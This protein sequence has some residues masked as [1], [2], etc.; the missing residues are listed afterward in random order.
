MGPDE[1]CMVVGKDLKK[2][3]E[4]SSSFNS[5]IYC[6]WPSKSDSAPVRGDGYEP[7]LRSSDPEPTQRRR[8]ACGQDLVVVVGVEGGGE[9][10]SDGEILKTTTVGPL[11]YDDYYTVLSRAPVRSNM[12]EQFSI[13]SPKT[14]TESIDDL[15]STNGQ[16]RTN[17]RANIRPL[18][19]PRAIARGACGH[20]PASITEYYLAAWITTHGFP[21]LLSTEW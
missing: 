3:I 12:D 8:T 4:R 19:T 15:T 5:T 16:A 21:Y 1:N 14:P 20:S 11:Q 13:T 6:V 9:K 7:G 17:E 10:F 18:L 2:Y